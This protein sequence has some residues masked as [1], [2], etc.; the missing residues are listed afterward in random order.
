LPKDSL[1]GCFWNPKIISLLLNSYK[2]LHKRLGQHAIV[3]AAARGAWHGG[4]TRG[5]AA[6]GMI[7]DYKKPLTWPRE[8]PYAARPGAGVISLGGNPRQNE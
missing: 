4:G 7:V 3:I 5:S 6:G 2:K 8:V 1:P